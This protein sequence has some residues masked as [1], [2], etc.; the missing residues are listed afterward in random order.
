MCRASGSQFNC[1]LSIARHVATIDC[2][3]VSLRPVL[4]LGQSYQIQL[5]SFNDFRGKDESR[6]S[7]SPLIFVRIFCIEHLR[8]SDQCC[9]PSYTTGTVD[10]STC[11]L[12]Y[13]LHPAST[14][15]G[16]RPPAI[17]KNSSCLWLDVD[18][19]DQLFLVTGVGDPHV[20]TIDNGRFTCHVQGIY[21]FAQTTANA[22]LVASNNVNTSLTDSDALFPDDLFSINVFSVFVAPALPYITRTQGYGSIFSS[23]T[24]ITSVYTFVLGNSGGRFSK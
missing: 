7:V 8:C 2:W 3:E 11:Q 1:C 24:I 20:N 9:F 22:Q 12:Y 16:Y 19:R 6:S 13:Q 10:W 17:G 5:L 15:T 14:C 23:Y 21:V 4:W 18:N